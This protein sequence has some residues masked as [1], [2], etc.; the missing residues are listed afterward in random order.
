MLLRYLLVPYDCEAL[1]LAC[2]VTGSRMLDFELDVGLGVVP[3]LGGALL[4]RRLLL[5]LIIIIIMGDLSHGRYGQ[6]RYPN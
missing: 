5:L 4:A 3:E 2:Y 1:I 6:H